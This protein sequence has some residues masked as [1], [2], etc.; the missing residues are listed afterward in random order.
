[1]AAYPPAV[2]LLLEKYAKVSPLMW[3]DIQ[4]S[5]RRKLLVD[6]RTRP[7]FATSTLK[8]SVLLTSEDDIAEMIKALANVP[9]EV[10][11]VVP[12]CT[13]GYRSGQMTTALCA[14][15][16]LTALVNSGLI[17]IRN[18]AGV[19]PFSHEEGCEFVCDD[20]ATN[21]VHVFGNEWNV[22]GG[23]FEAVQFD[24]GVGALLWEWILGWFGRK[25]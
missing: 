12:F 20:V 24:R 9:G 7:E 6:C 13:I 18:G 2:T 25:Y 16:D 14:R 21:R 23:G 19:V 5:P 11:L 17:E 8:G 3:R 1:M 22:L 4:I 15:E 10:L